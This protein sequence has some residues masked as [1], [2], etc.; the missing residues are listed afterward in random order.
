MKTALE[1]I[2]QTIITAGWS[3]KSDGTVES[4]QGHFAVVEIP[5]K[6]EELVAMVDAI[7]DMTNGE[8]VVAL[9]T[10]TRGF[11]FVVEDDQGNVY[12]NGAYS[13]ASA[14]LLFEKAQAVLVKWHEAN[15]EDI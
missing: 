9:C 10:A 13:E 7:L 12:V 14:N 3:N 5:E 11:Y 15:E 4:P 1:S 8:E 2:M 6:R